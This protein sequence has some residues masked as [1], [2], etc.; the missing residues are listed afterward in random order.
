MSDAVVEI[1]AALEGASPA[2]WAVSER[3]EEAARGWREIVLAVG[4]RRW[5]ICGDSFERHRKV[6]DEYE[7]EFHNGVRITEA[8]AKLIVAMRNNIEALLE[9]VERLRGLAG[10]R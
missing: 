9:E 10:Q 5:V 8:D 7:T 1:R 3:P 4:P 6:Y 2:G